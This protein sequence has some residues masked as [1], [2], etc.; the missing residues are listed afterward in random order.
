MSSSS[1]LSAGED[2]KEKATASAGAEA[3]AKKEEEHPEKKAMDFRLSPTWLASLSPSQMGDL[4]GDLKFLGRKFGL[5][6]AVLEAASPSGNFEIRLVA[7]IAATLE[8][9][10]VELTQSGLLEHYEAQARPRS[11]GVFSCASVA[12]RADDCWDRPPLAESDVQV[13]K[14]GEQRVDPEDGQV[15]TWTAYKTHYKDQYSFDDL[16][17]YWRLMQKV[18]P[19]STASVPSKVVR[20]RRAGA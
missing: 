8:S 14:D 7:D 12:L 2:A 18:P 1:T 19:A 4:R 5:A 20:P 15:W 13:E 17:A 16:S 10:R 11:G 9:A 6:E 3:L